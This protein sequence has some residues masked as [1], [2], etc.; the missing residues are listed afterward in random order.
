MEVLTFFR[1]ATTCLF[2][3]VAYTKAILLRLGSHKT[4]AQVCYEIGRLGL[5][6]LYRVRLLCGPVIKY[7]LN[8]PTPTL[9]EHFFKSLEI[10]LFFRHSATTGIQCRLFILDWSQST[11]DLLDFLQVTRANDGSWLLNLTL[12]YP[13]SWISFVL[14]RW[15]IQFLTSPHEHNLHV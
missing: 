6:C 9:Y 14:A 4:V 12:I 13:T 15:D 5:K 11:S 2:D 10:P 1:Q 8:S 3:M 7:L